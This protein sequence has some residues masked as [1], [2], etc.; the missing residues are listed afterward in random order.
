MTISRR[1]RQFGELTSEDFAAFPVWIA[2]HCVDFDEPWYDET[3]EETFRP[4]DKPLP[5][6]PKDGMLLVSATMILADGRLL[7]GFLTPQHDTETLDLGIVQ[8]QI[9]L[10][11]G[12][13]A[14][15]W[16]GAY[17][18][19]DSRRKILYAELGDDPNS[20]FPISFRADV[21]LST[22]HTCGSIP[23]FCWSP[24]STVNVYH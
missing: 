17:K 16:D 24:K 13:R 10:L 22:G 20:I 9:F 4:W 3:D 15:F 5:A 18:R 23:G 21:G 14:D 19:P 7:T 11:S 12:T 8:P 1:L 6:S 2:C